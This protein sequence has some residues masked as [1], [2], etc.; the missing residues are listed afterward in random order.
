MPYKIKN[1]F[2]IHV[3]PPR[4]ERG[5]KWVQAAG[6]RRLWRVAPPRGERGLK[7]GAA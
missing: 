2:A 6:S 1:I 3:A 7:C 5:L 4:G